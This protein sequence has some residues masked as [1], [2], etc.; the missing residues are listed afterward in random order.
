MRTM[1]FTLWNGTSRLC[2]LTGDLDGW[3][4]VVAA[5]GGSVLTPRAR[6][7]LEAHGFSSDLYGGIARMKWGDC[8]DEPLAGKLELELENADSDAS[9]VRFDVG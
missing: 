5:D 4:K 8:P 7:W 1:R 9:R 3:S 2:S 6:T